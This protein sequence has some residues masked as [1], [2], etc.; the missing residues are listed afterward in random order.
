MALQKFNTQQ[1]ESVANDIKRQGVQIKQ[2]MEELSKTIKSLDGFWEGDTAKAFL[3]EFES[4]KPTLN[5]MELCAN[6]VSQQLL[7]VVQI[8]IET[9]RSIAS[10]IKR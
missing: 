6:G 5:K 7:K 8:K 3:E 2:L 4:L 1:A 10:Q 9:E